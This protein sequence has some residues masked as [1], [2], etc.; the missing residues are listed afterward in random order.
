MLKDVSDELHGQIGE[1]ERRG[2]R[3]GAVMSFRKRVVEDRYSD[4]LSRVLGLS[5]K[6]IKHHGE[7]GYPEGEA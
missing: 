6:G 2:H 3:D 4:V 1:D 5:D 7:L